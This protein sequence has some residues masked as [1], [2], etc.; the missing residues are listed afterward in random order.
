M[1]TAQGWTTPVLTPQ[2]S[3]AAAATC[4][5]SIGAG[6]ISAFYDGL[7]GITGSSHAFSWASQ[8]AGAPVLTN[9]LSPPPT[10][11]GATGAVTFNGT[12]QSL[13]HTTAS[14][15][16]ALNQAY[17]IA[18]VVSGA[19]AG[20]DLGAWVNIADGGTF[21]RSL[22]I[23]PNFSGTANTLF[24]GYSGTGSQYEVNTTLAFNS[25]NTYLII[26]SQDASLLYVNAVPLA[27][28]TVAN[29]GLQASGSNFLSLG[30]S[31]QQT[32]SE[33]LAGSLN[34]VVCFPGVVTPTQIGYLTTYASNYVYTPA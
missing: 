33:Y 32:V 20:N 12:T 23:G 34:G 21:N 27:Q 17:S 8:V 22:G 7:N 31:Y 6:N 18:I 1:P 14:A 16:F 10:Y 2:Y 30:N 11:N 24:A 9:H 13:W 29:G 28:A 5:A 4:I 25:A 15:V 19:G 3:P 26:V